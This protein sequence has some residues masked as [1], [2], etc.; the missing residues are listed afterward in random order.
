MGVGG[1]QAT[2]PQRSEGGS[3]EHEW[4]TSAAQ[5]HV[6]TL[7]AYRP[8]HIREGKGGL[9]NHHLRHSK[10]KAADKASNCL[11]GQRQYWVASLRRPRLGLEKWLSG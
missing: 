10:D 6:P 2:D 1:T 7:R 8:S 3:A 11:K 9:A 5:I 4:T